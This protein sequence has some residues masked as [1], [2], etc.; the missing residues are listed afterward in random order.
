MLGIS[1]DYTGTIET[2]TDKRVTL[3]D[4]R[5][6]ATSSARRI[7]VLVGEQKLKYKLKVWR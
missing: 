5:Y 3:A 6:L 7:I 1:M 4:K 2:I